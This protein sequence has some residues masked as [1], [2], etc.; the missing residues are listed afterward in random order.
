[1]TGVTI[2]SAPNCRAVIAP[3]R[4][5][6]TKVPSASAISGRSASPSVETMASNFCSAAQS[7]RASTSSG[8]RASVSTGMKLDA[9][10]SGIASAPSASRICDQQCP[11][12]QNCADRP[13]RGGLPDNAAESNPDS[14]LHRFQPGPDVV[15]VL[16]MRAKEKRP[17]SISAWN[18]RI[19]CSSCFVDFA[20]GA[21]EFQP[22]AVIR[23]MA[24][25]HHDRWGSLAPWRRRKGQASAALRNRQAPGRHRQWR[26]GTVAQC[27]DCSNARSRPTYTAFPSRMAPRSRSMRA[28]AS[29]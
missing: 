22:V 13:R 10:P 18:F 6:R 12:Q 17:A 19:S 26:H 28:K 11:A 8:R 2:Q 23:N 1:M 14:A 16:S 21:I 3:T 4:S 20:I 27:L 9:R 29:E 24:A 7:L 15:A 5:P 25:G